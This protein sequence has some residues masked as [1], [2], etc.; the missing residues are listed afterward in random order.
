M[1][2]LSLNIL[3]ITNNSVK[4]SADTIEIA[5]TESEKDD[6]V[7]ILIADNGCGMSAEFVEK[8]TDPFVTTRTTRKIGLGLPLLKQSAIDTDG[9][10]EIT[11]K[12]GIG[13][14]VYADFRLTHLDRA[15]LGDMAS[16]VTTLI[17]AAPDIRY[18]YTHTT[19]TGTF[20]FDTD[21]IKK[22]LD[23]I[24]LTEPDILM[25]ISGYIK[26]NLQNI[27]GGNI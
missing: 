26:D 10:F 27:N 11:S 22:E 16:T 2:E 25:W 15:P 12:P 8:V 9:H 5:V 13:T 19:D 17:S 4:A 7:S 23:G 3:D 20:I 21:E 6:K 1:K 24:P 14:K 18:V